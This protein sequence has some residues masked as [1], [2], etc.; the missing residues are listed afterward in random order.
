MTE[1]TDTL[2]SANPF[3]SI[4]AEL[5]GMT[6]PSYIMFF[7]SHKFENGKKCNTNAKKTPPIPPKGTAA[8]R[9]TPPKGGPN[10]AIK[11]AAVE[12]KEAPIPVVPA[13]STTPS[14][15]TK[16]PPARSSQTSGAAHP[17]ISVVVP[18]TGT[19]DDENTQEELT[20]EGGIAATERS[21]SVAYTNLD[22][23]T[24]DQSAVIAVIR[25]Y[26]TQHFFQHVKFINRM[27]KLA[28]LTQ[29]RILE[30]IAR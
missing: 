8:K 4:V 11:K 24:N 26:V 23:K 21:A 3:E 27:K 9:K 10:L 20:M 12:L 29:K 19:T 22:R 30:H 1:L 2:W 6:K 14:P 5:Q 18:T 13:T 25:N 7:L 28:Y 15:D 16:S 17:V